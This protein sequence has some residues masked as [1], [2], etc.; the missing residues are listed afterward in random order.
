MVELTSQL[1]ASLALT[2]WGPRNGAFVE[3]Q[4]AMLRGSMFG[5]DPN[6]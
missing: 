4:P 3:L 5:G 6:E 1:P 2:S